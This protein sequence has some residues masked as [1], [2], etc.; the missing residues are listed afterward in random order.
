[1]REHLKKFIEK[2]PCPVFLEYIGNHN[3]EERFAI[4]S[5]EE[6]MIE[7]A[8]NLAEFINKHWPKGKYFFGEAR[9]SLY[10][11]DGKERFIH[12][13]LMPRLPRFSLCFLFIRYMIKDLKL[14]PWPDPE[15]IEDITL[16]A[17]YII[18]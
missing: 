6:E 17:Y 4:F 11:Q 18:L 1:M 13:S 15:N 10:I 9:A 16:N 2:H 7:A 5:T 8:Q 3:E 14:E 12:V